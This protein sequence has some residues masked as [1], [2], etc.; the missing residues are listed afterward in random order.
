VRTRPGPY[1]PVDIGVALGDEEDPRVPRTSMD[2][3]T[4]GRS[5]GAPP[6]RH[7]QRPQ[8]AIQHTLS[9]AEQGQRTWAQRQCARAAAEAQDVYKASPRV[10]GPEIAGAFGLAPTQDPYSLRGFTAD[11]AYA[12]VMEYRREHHRTQRQITPDKVSTADFAYAISRSEKTLSRWL[13]DLVPDLADDQNMWP[14]AYVTG[15][16]ADDG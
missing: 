6:D 8:Q 10:R 12:R 16:R 2:S 1:G 3:V 9:A 11:V 13:G 7:A 4:G 14:R 5:F 15:G